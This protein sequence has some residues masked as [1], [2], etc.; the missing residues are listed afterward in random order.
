MPE[1]EKEKD[2]QQEIKEE[3]NL[4]L[5]D[6]HP[7]SELRLRKQNQLEVRSILKT[8]LLL[9][10]SH[11]YSELRL[12]KVTETVREMEIHLYKCGKGL[13]DAFKSNLGG[14]EQDQLEELLRR[15]E[16]S[17]RRLVGKRNLGFQC[18]DAHAR[19]CVK[20]NEEDITLKETESTSSRKQLRVRP[21]LN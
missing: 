11:P 17:W 9:D 20:H 10:D 5:D 8:T 16:M 19:G 18:L 6:S 15:H 12:R 21:K 13:I 2:P 4:L 14:W 3:T 1:K 7:Y